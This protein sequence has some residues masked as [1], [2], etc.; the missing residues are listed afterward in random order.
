MPDKSSMEKAYEKATGDGPIETTLET[1]EEKLKEMIRAADKVI[2]DAADTAKK[3]PGAILDAAETV[4][5]A[6]IAHQTQR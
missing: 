2:L 6:G 3:V 4:V 5:G 1:A